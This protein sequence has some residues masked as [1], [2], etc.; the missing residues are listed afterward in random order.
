MVRKLLKDG[1][2]HIGQIISPLYSA[3][4]LSLSTT[5]GPSDC[6]ATCCVMFLIAPLPLRYCTLLFGGAVA[7]STGFDGYQRIEVIFFSNFGRRRLNSFPNLQPTLHFPFWVRRP[8]IVR[9]RQGSPRCWRCQLCFCILSFVG[10][11]LMP[12]E[13]VLSMA[14][15]RRGPW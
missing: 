8:D 4:S 6:C 2:L 14:I 9:W 3:A 1:T 10:G 15:H 7:R 5:V 12:A 13:P 11:P